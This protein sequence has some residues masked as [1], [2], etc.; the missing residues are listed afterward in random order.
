[1][2]K[3]MTL[4]LLAIL[5]IL[6]YGCTKFY[7]KSPYVTFNHEQHVNIL[8]EQKKDCFYCHKLPDVETF[9]T[10]GADFKIGAELKIDNTCHSCHKD[11]LT[12]L[13]SAPKNCYACHENMKTMMPDDHLN[14]W[15]SMHTVPATLDKKSC[16]SCHSDWYCETCHSKQYTKDGYRHSRSFKVF[17]AVE[18]RLDPSSCDSCH[19]TNFCLD[20]HKKN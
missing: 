8:F 9:I 16:E 13:P 14:Q 10:Q 15:V 3:R 5:P 20:C 11:E 19:K 7:Y 18:A 1:M 12:K 6:F 2:Q 17:H 4:V